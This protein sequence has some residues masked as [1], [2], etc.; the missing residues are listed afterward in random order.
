MRKWIYGSEVRVI[1]TAP[2][3]ELF[4]K[5]HP[6]TIPPNWQGE[7]SNGDAGMAAHFYEQK[8]FREML[9]IWN[10]LKSSEN[11]TSFRMCDSRLT[12][13]RIVATPVSLTFIT[14]LNSH[15]DSA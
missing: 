10:L 6:N 15:S 4:L 3:S 5:V 9:R 2:T 13:P 8:T 12:S 7:P 14:F 11:S 1:L